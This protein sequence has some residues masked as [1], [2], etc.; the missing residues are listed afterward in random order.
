MAFGRRQGQDW[1]NLVLGI[2]LIFS[3][4]F[5]FAATSTAA[6][7]SAGVTGLLVATV[8]MFSLSRPHYWQEVVNLAL[9]LWLIAA[10]L[11]LGFSN[12]SDATINH[13]LVGT[14]VSVLALWA[15]VRRI[16]RRPAT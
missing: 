1:L 5:G 6:S 15:L 11:A 2:W 8:A 14:A 4:L 13:V 10:P 12:S 3:P 7:M 16:R 9:G